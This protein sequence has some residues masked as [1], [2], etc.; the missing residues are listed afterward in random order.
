MGL[1]GNT[2][3][4]I[5]LVV[6]YVIIF[7]IFA[8]LINKDAHYDE[9]Q[10]Q[11]RANGYKI[12]FFFV[13]IGV[14]VII[15]LIEATDIFSRYITPSFA[16]GIVAYGALALFSVYCIFKDAYYSI[17]QNRILHILI[18]LCIIIPNGIGAYRNIV[19]RTVVKNELIAFS[20][21]GNMLCATC[22]LII[23]I[24][25][26]IKAAKEKREEVE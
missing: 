24:A 6:V 12:G 9:R 1:L 23:L 3:T 22:F 17:N 25:L 20:N 2:W 10:L 11:F 13:M 26:I 19:E 4:P 14:F 16:L 5:I 15:F 21:S 8:R 7:I 18:C